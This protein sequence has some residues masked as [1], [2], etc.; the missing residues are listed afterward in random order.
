L[1]QEI[2]ISVAT[3][4]MKINPYIS[5]TLVWTIVAYPTNTDVNGT[6]IFVIILAQ[7]TGTFIGMVLV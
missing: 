3:D 6:E 1:L 4:V 7:L 5:I 2:N